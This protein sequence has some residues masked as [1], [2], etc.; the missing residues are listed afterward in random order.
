MKPI[1]LIMEAFGP[2]CDEETV[3]FTELGEKTMFLIHGPT[4]AGKTTILDAICY[5]LYGET[6]SGNVRSGQNMISQY[7]EHDSTA[8]VVFEFE[9]KSQKYMAERTLN[10]EKKAKNKALLYKYNNENKEYTVIETKLREVTNRVTELIGFDANQFRQVILIPQGEFKKLL[11]SDVEE[12][13][14]IM[15]K[16]FG[17]QKY[18]IL[19]DTAK[20]KAAVIYASIKE[21]EDK[22]NWILETLGSSNLEETNCILKK[23]Y[24]DKES[25]NGDL[26]VKNSQIQT[27]QENLK[28]SEI[29]NMKL[30]DLFSAESDI[31]KLEQRENEILS[32]IKVVG[33]AKKALQL[34]KFEGD[35]NKLKNEVN[36]IKDDLTKKG[37]ELKK[38]QLNLCELNDNIKTLDKKANERED[39]SR[40]LLQISNHEI[41]VK[42]LADEIEKKE[43]LELH[44]QQSSEKINKLNVFINN[45]ETKITQL[46]EDIQK[47]IHAANESEIE[48]LQIEQKRKNLEKLN[49]LKKVQEQ[50]KKIDKE[51]KQADYEFNKSKTAYETIK[52]EFEM[53]QKK[54]IRGQA[55]VLA[56]NLREGDPCP[57][58]GSISHSN[59]A[60]KEIGIPSEVELN[61]KKAIM[62]RYENDKDEYSKKVTQLSTELTNILEL[63]DRI[64]SELG[65]FQQ[66]DIKSLMQT[67]NES[68][69]KL[70]TLKCNASKIDILK[71]EM[72][73]NKAELEK[74]KMKYQESDNE[75]QQSSDKYRKQI[76]IIE[77]LESSIPEDL[78]SLEL[79]QNK[80]QHLQYVLEEMNI[81]V[82]NA[83]DSQTDAIK[84]C[85]SLESSIK[86]S[87]VMYHEKSEEYELSKKEYESRIISLDFADENEYLDSKHFIREIENDE[88]NIIEYQKKLQSA[89]DR[90]LKAKKDSSGKEKQ[91]LNLIRGELT[92]VTKQ[93]DDLISISGNITM[94]IE[95]IN[96]HLDELI[97][98][99]EELKNNQE[100]Y[101]IFGDLSNI[102]N[103]RDGAKVDIERFVLISL[104]EEVTSAANNRLKVMSAGRYQLL[105]R[106]EQLDGRHKGGLDLDVLDNYTGDIRHV[107]TLSGGESFLASLSY[108]LGLA[109]VVQAHSGGISLDTMFI[110][111]GFGTLD[112]ESLDFAIKTL[113]DLQEGGRLVG[114]ISHVPELKERIDARLEV[115]KTEKGSRVK[116]S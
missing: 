32:L 17:T 49:E 28:K 50:S 4:G 16:M 98:L 3:D 26:E 86:T 111:E 37:L 48:Q 74:L 104:L 84:K 70:Q 97:K 52:D 15:A 115:I 108:A 34:E 72:D 114:I 106:T 36:K 90:Y 51:L 18:K 6:S 103:G 13:Q 83:K 19:A 31:K 94:E 63:E 82:K 99:E 53:L 41:G 66:N 5:A 1:K 30:D 100:Q 78:R 75:L 12:R 77:Q 60:I 58:C 71:I 101:K 80:K 45:L 61:T 43:T 88:L 62:D 42:K 116:F 20:N 55:G 92:R 57:V 29:I 79:L 21:R 89:Q 76:G 107:S 33:K 91:D 22:K 112:S 2:Y 105:T 44:Y 69:K 113:M 25:I 47:N 96:K 10:A 14:K 7:V 87:E 95:N 59:L 85:S 38:A 40:R 64:K 8:R 56:E 23:K 67:I 93:K 35:K 65:N 39:I 9:L 27:L 102:L 68:E 46:N 54:W 109:D 81:A 73:N 110:D 11:S 24:D